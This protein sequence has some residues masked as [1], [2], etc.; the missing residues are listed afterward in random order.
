MAGEVPEREHMEASRA[1]YTSMARLARA[2]YERGATPREVLRSCYGVEFPEEFLMM[3][4]LWPWRPGL[5]P[6][7]TNQPWKLAV[8]LDRGGPPPTPDSLNRVEQEILARDPDLL[9]LARLRDSSLTLGNSIICYRLGALAAGHT[10]GFGMKN[11]DEYDFEV[12]PWG[13][14]LLDLLHRYYVEYHMR[15]EREYLSPGNR[16][17]GSLD[18]DDV[19]RAASYVA[20]VE[21]LR[22]RLISRPRP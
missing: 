10:T 12:A 4:Q 3:T 9:P 15:T 5:S 1:D 16:G 21:E 2:M 7:Y 19:E 22:Q 17:A 18:E 6:S 20:K 8:P 11:P 14:S 13:D